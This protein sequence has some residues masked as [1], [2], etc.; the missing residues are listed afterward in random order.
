MNIWQ[1]GLWAPK[2]RPQSSLQACRA[3]MLWPRRQTRTKARKHLR[4][5]QRGIHILQMVPA[6]RTPELTHVKLEQLYR[7]IATDRS[8]VSVH[9]HISNA[10]R[11]AYLGVD[12]LNKNLRG[13]LELDTSS[14]TTE[15]LQQRRAILQAM[16]KQCDEDVQAVLK[17]LGDLNSL[18]QGV[19]TRE[20]LLKK[21]SIP[22]LES[23]EQTESAPKMEPAHSTDPS[24]ALSSKPVMLSTDDRGSSKV[25]LEELDKISSKTEPNAHRVKRRLQAKR[26]TRLSKNFEQRPTPASP[27]YFKRNRIL[28][29]ESVVLPKELLMVEAKVNKL[30]RSQQHDVKA[31]AF[32]L[33]RMRLILHVRRRIFAQNL[34]GNGLSTV[35]ALLTYWNKAMLVY[36]SHDVRLSPELS[37]PLIDQLRIAQDIM[38]ACR[39]PL[40]RTISRMKT[41]EAVVRAKARQHSTSQSYPDNHDGLPDTFLPGSRNRDLKNR[42]GA[43]YLAMAEELMWRAEKGGDT[44][45]SNLDCLKDRVNLILEGTYLSRPEQRIAR[46]YM[47]DVLFKLRRFENPVREVR[48]MAVKALE[49]LEEQARVGYQASAEYAAL[50]FPKEEAASREAREMEIPSDDQAL[51]SY[52]SAQ[53]ND[54]KREETDGQRFKVL[55]EVLND[56]FHSEKTLDVAGNRR[57]NEMDVS[58]IGTQLKDH[59]KQGLGILQELATQP[60]APQRKATNFTSAELVTSAQHPSDFGQSPEANYKQ[61]QKKGSKQDVSGLQK[62]IGFHEERLKIIDMINAVDPDAFLHLR[63]QSQLETGGTAREGEK[64]TGTLTQDHIPDEQNNPTS[65]HVADTAAEAELEDQAQYRLVSEQT[66]VAEKTPKEA[67]RTIVNEVGAEIRPPRQQPILKERKPNSVE[68][69]ET[70]IGPLPSQA[71]FFQKAWGS[72]HNVDATPQA[73]VPSATPAESSRNEIE[74][75]THPLIPGTKTTEPDSKSPSTRKVEPTGPIPTQTETFSKAW[76]RQ[77]LDK[78]LTPRTKPAFV[79]SPV[80]KPIENRTRVIRE[81]KGSGPLPGAAAQFLKTWLGDGSRGGKE[82]RG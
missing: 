40:S 35:S 34:D 41:L 23:C 66:D 46:G 39:R 11:S 80:G 52:I 71:A 68:S 2:A 36:E 33:L 50:N 21:T 47:K 26:M 15:L 20:S 55:F 73:R 43:S 63:E 49:I 19:L 61:L 12:A 10:A 69:E 53:S 29:S 18:Y 14:Y 74:V 37:Q 28:E 62:P 32:N 58:E 57:V 59:R 7:D 72:G 42:F 77:V 24:G 13:Y 25:Q 56:E 17:A 60:E 31:K 30:S 27:N 70:Q 65:L 4:K 38:L 76:A 51:L 44:V 8:Y 45:Q 9:N 64:S 82:R 75:S 48:M 5:I 78:K 81:S 3:P 67:S 79:K 22:L 6:P 54:K 16:N 1:R